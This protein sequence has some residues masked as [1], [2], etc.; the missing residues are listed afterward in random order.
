MELKTVLYIEELK[1]T[2]LHSNIVMQL[3]NYHLLIKLI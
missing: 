3:E 1:K 2:M